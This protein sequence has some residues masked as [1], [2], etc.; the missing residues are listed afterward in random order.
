MVVVHWVDSSLNCGEETGRVAW[1]TSLLVPY[2]LRGIINSFYASI[3]K[4]LWYFIRGLIN[5]LSQIFKMILS[6]T[7]LDLKFLFQ[8][9]LFFKIIIRSLICFIESSQNIIF[10]LNKLIILFVQLTKWWFGRCHT[11]FQIESR[12][13]FLK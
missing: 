8:H 4:L 5:L 10:I 11:I 13:V 12:L 7:N 6:F 1:T 9:F 3:W 2:F